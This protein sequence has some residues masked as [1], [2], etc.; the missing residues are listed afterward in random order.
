MKG[1]ATF[2]HLRMAS[3]PRTTC[4]NSKLPHPHARKTSYQNSSHTRMAQ[5]NTPYTK[6]VAKPEYQQD[7]NPKIFALPRGTA[8]RYPHYT[9]QDSQP[10]SQKDIQSNIFATRAAL[11]SHLFQRPKPHACH[12]KPRNGKAAGT[13]TTPICTSGPLQRPKPHSCHAKAAGAAKQPA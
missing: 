13:E 1:K 8:T 5:L 7:I 12:A 11:K 2:S 6:Q 9:Q 3:L 4:I 10:T